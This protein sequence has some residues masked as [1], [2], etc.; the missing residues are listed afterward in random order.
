MDGFRAVFFIAMK[1]YT[2]A[3]RLAGAMKAERI[4]T[5]EELY[6]VSP[7]SIAEAVELIRREEKLMG[8]QLKREQYNVEYIRS[9]LHT[10]L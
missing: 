8:V 7:C 4:P 3:G 10:P 2:D 5:R 9:D 1:H 6:P